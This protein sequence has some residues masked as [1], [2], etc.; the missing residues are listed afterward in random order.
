LACLAALLTL[1]LVPV[2]RAGQPTASGQAARAGA[3]PAVT[4][5]GKK[6]KAACRKQ[7]KAN[8]IAFNQIKNHTFIGTRGDGEPVEETFCANGKYE[9]NVGGGISTGSRWQVFEAKVSAGGKSITAFIEGSGGFEVALLR[10]AG[11]WQVA[12]ASLGRALDPGDATRS[13]AAATCK[14]L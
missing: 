3:G 11:Q 10:R 8:R 9:S 4:K 7:N 12:I 13:N 2:A 6:G 1:A 5:C 14:K